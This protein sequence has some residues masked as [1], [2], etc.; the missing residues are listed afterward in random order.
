MKSYNYK[1]TVISKLRRNET[2]ESREKDETR[3]SREKEKQSRSEK[4]ILSFTYVNLFS[5]FVKSSL[6]FYRCLYIHIII[7]LQYVQSV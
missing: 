1:G 7:R 3:E 5:F 4:A 2:R 6:T